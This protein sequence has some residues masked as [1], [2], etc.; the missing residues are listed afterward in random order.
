[1]AFGTLQADLTLSTVT[2]TGGAPGAVSG[3]IAVLAE[4]ALPGNSASVA[5]A[6]I[7]ALLALPNSLPSTAGQLWWNGG[8]LSK[9]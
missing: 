9:S 6:V 3:D 4:A 8:T 7:A 5:A 1:M 2:P